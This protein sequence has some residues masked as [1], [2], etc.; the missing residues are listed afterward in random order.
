MCCHDKDKHEHEHSHEGC[1]HSHDGQEH[2]MRPGLT[3]TSTP[4]QT[5]TISTITSVAINGNPRVR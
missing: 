5:G 3:P 1:T 4:T 2:P